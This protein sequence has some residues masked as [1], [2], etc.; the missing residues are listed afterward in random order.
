MRK[1]LWILG[2]VAAG[3]VGLILLAPAALWWETG[4]RQK[5]W[6]AYKESL[7]RQGERLDWEDFIGSRPPDE[8]NFFATPSLRPLLEG[9]IVLRENGEA[10]FAD[11]GKIRAACRMP[12]WI[13]LLSL[14]PGCMAGK[15]LDL[16]KA[17][18]SLE[19]A[20]GRLDP[21][22]AAVLGQTNLSAADRVE[23]LVSIEEP[24]LAELAAAARRSRAWLPYWTNRASFFISLPEWPFLKAAGRMF[25]LR[26][27]VRVRHNRSREA[28]EDVETALRLLRAPTNAPS[29]LAAF[30]EAALLCD[31]CRPIWEGLAA[32]RWGKEDLAALQEALDRANYVRDAKLCFRGERAFEIGVFKSVAERWPWIGNRIAGCLIY[33]NMRLLAESFQEHCL[34]VLDAE[35]GVVR[36]GEFRIRHA[37]FFETLSHTRHPYRFLAA[38][39]FQPVDRVLV[40]IARRQSLI[41]MAR[42]A[43]AL[44]RFRLRFGRYPESLDQLAPRFLA[45][46]P[47]DPSTGERLVYRLEEKDKF[48][49]YSRGP[50]GEDDGGR[51]I[52]NKR[53]LPDL[54]AKDSDWVWSYTPVPLLSG[55]PSGG[56]SSVEK[57]GTPGGTRT[58]NPLIRSQM[59][60]PIELPAHRA[61]EGLHKPLCLPTSKKRL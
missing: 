52:L 36:L 9:R 26:A 30:V 45:Q 37:P 28:V 57:N 16:T 43:V 20:S 18:A 7:E 39:S 42:A 54:G 46:T 29:F 3:L 22:A 10:A 12:E 27:T 19:S 40:V 14:S 21:K 41:S 8:E 35:R 32:R 1:L 15:P 60:Y 47:V 51:I 2:G 23:R 56:R 58:P 4:R 31:A 49:L 38:M 34:P 25:S 11:E 44:E 5:R 59:L 55:G 53:G 17:L 61:K 50:D 48:V 24:R 33:A 6:E 13:R